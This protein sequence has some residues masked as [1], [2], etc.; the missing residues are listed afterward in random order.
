MTHTQTHI[1]I[2]IFI[3]LDINEKCNINKVQY[4]FLPSVCVHRIADKYFFY[5]SLTGNYNCYVPANWICVKIHV[6]IIAL[7]YK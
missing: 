6:A 2:C 5:L 3:Y 1:N 7:C 4:S